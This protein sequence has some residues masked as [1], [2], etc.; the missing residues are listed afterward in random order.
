M[1]YQILIIE[2]D[3]KLNNLIKDYLQK[4]SHKVY[5]AKEYEEAKKYLFKEKIDLVILDIMLPNVNGLEICKLIRQ[6]SIIPIIFLSARGEVP[7]RVVGLEI[8][9]DDYLTKP[10]EP[11]ELLARIEAVLRRAKNNPQPV[12]EQ[13]TTINNL[14]IDWKDKKVYLKDK[15]IRLTHLEFE[16]LSLLVKNKGKILEREYIIEQLYDGEWD[17]FNRAIDVLLG[18]L[19]KKIDNDKNAPLIKSVWGRGYGVEV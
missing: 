18:R 1:A 4:Y 7:D 2:D 6:Q 5:Q 10:F 3:A 9:A 8:G 12:K 14:K 15:H 13:V 19:R 11:R 16:L 17:G